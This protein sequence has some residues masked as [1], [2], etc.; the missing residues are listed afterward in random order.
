M[1]TTSW[2]PFEGFVE[3]TGGRLLYTGGDLETLFSRLGEEFQSQYYLGYDVDPKQAGKRRRRI[4]SSAATRSHVT[5]VHGFTA[6]RDN[7]AALR[8]AIFSMTGP[9]WRADAVY[10]L[11]FLPSERSLPVLLGAA[12]DPDEK[13]REPRG[14]GARRAGRR[15]G[16]CRRSWISWATR[17]CVRAA[18]AIPSSCSPAGRRR[19]SSGRSP[20]R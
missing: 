6:S 3:E 16:D 2:L 14:P 4:K 15:R 13:V 9:G 7:F 17:P 12:A 5:T 11:S 1:S 8:V 18:A 19:S 20:G 10:E